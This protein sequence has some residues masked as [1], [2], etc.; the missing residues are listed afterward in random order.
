MA[1][2]SRCQRISRRVRDDGGAL[3]AAERPRCT[4]ARALSAAIRRMRHGGGCRPIACVAVATRQRQE[5]VPVRGCCL[6]RSVGVRSLR[7]GRWR[8]IGTATPTAVSFACCSSDT[9]SSPAPGRIRRQWDRA[10]GHGRS[11]MRRW[12]M[13]RVQGAG[14]RRREHGQPK[15]ASSSLDRPT[16]LRVRPR[17]AWHRVLGVHARVE[18]VRPPQ[19]CGARVSSVPRDSMTRSAWPY[20]RAGAGWLASVPSGRMHV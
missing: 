7:D 19:P 14:V 4:V 13:S 2:G 18:S 1:A 8:T 16:S 3:N 15:C 12:A 6:R 20:E 11:F 10:L 17:T 5:R 9:T